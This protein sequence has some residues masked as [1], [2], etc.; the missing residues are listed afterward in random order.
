MGSFSGGSIGYAYPLDD[1]TSYYEEDPSNTLEDS[2]TNRTSRSAGTTSSGGG[3][4]K[5][6]YERAQQSSSSQVGSTLYSGSSRR[7]PNRALR[8]KNTQNQQQNS[9]MSSAQITPSQQHSASLQSSLNS[10]SFGGGH[11]S[12]S[13][14]STSSSQRQ[15]S[16][17]T[18]MSGN[19][20][21][22]VGDHNE[23]PEELELDKDELKKMIIQDETNDIYSRSNVD[24]A[25]VALSTVGD[26]SASSVITPLT[27][28]SNFDSSSYTSSHPLV[29]QFLKIMHSQQCRRSLFLTILFALLAIGTFLTIENVIH[30]KDVNAWIEPSS[31]S[32]KEYH[33]TMGDDA[34]KPIR[35]ISKIS[36]AVQEYI[37]DWSVGTSYIPGVV[38]N[39]GSITMTDTTKFRDIPLFFGS[40]YADFE[41]NGGGSS[42]MEGVLGCLNLV[43]ASSEGV[44]ENNKGGSE[45]NNNVGVGDD[46]A[47][48]KPGEDYLQLSVVMSMGR[49]YINV[50][51][52]TKDGIERAKVLSL[53]SSGM[54]DVIYSS[55]LQDVSSLFTTLNQG[56]MFVLIRHPI[57]REMA[58]FRYLRRGQYERTKLTDW[59]RGLLQDMSYVEYAES[60]FARDNWMTRELVN[61]RC[62]SGKGEDGE[63]A[64][65]DDEDVHTAK[66]ILRRKAIIGLYSDI[67]GAVQHYG[68]YF[69]W[70]N[71]SKGGSFE[72]A[73]MFCFQNHIL[74]GMKKD[75]LGGKDLDH[76]DAIEHSEAYVALMEKN[77]FD[78][79]LFT[80]AQ[81]L[82]TYQI[83]LS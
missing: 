22:R 27:I 61:K 41:G 71:A 50:D 4:H 39:S 56:R 52:T 51:T 80:Y 21:H 36:P 15:P 49:K 8:F 70:D 1:N 12:S 37:A 40:E 46:G 76:N 11:L 54:A 68:R 28:S 30:V 14:M 81:T 2:E 16:A 67:V 72:D 34:P 35:G 31:N 25:S 48:N 59:Q 24:N 77:R 20:L 43:Q 6:I 66:E 58:R 63:C 23:N 82:Y 53:G 19:P 38:D 5:A 45:S 33:W 9:P 26:P 60:E 74:E 64:P 3:N 57:E 83:E 79:E 47:K 32:N 7:R 18:S 75:A 44:M 13:F 29:Q 17:M 10:S 65:L 78:F 73:T 69:G 62:I 42:I 55:L